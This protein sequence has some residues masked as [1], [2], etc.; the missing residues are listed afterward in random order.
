[1]NSAVVA[2]L[3]VAIMSAVSITI[4]Y[5]TEPIVYTLADFSINTT[6]TAGVNTTG[7]EQGIQ[8]LQTIN[9][10]WIAVVLGVLITYAVIATLR[11]EGVSYYA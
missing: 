10:L 8:L 5:L 3:F 11:R 6:R 9:V 1:M 4:W 7:Y 2:W